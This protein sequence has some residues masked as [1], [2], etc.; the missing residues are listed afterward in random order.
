MPT[1]LILKNRVEVA[2]VQ[3]ADPRSL[4]SAVE[5]YA[6]EAKSAGATFATSGKG[7]TLGSTAATT[8][9]AAGAAAAAGAGVG[10]GSAGARYVRN[11]QVLDS[12]PVPA[13]LRGFFNAFVVFVG[14]YLTSLFSLDAIPAAE[15]SPFNITRGTGAKANVRSARGPGHA[16]P[17]PGGPVGRRL[18]TLDSIRGGG[19]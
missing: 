1:F 11:G 16:A 14:L 8:T 9:T 10:A 12:M 3:G 15:N 2:R 5:K 18:G 4:T 7:Y 17:S 13:R 6:G 19:G